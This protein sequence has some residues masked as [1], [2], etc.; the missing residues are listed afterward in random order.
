MTF[1]L[2][3]LDELVSQGRGN[4]TQAA[5]D[6]LMA[7]AGEER[8]LRRNA[9]AYD[10][11][12]L[13]PRFL[14]GNSPPDT[15]ADVM[16]CRVSLPVLTAP[17]GADGTLHPD[18][19]KAVAQ[20]CQDV[21]TVAVVPASS[22]FAF[23]QVAAAAPQ[24]A[25]VAQVHAAGSVQAFRHLLTRISN[26]GYASVCVT[27]DTPTRGWRDRVRNSDVVRDPQLRNANYSDESGGFLGELH[28]QTVPTW[29]WEQLH[30]VCSTSSL[31]FSV[32]GLLS[33][34]DALLAADAGAFAVVV[35]NHGGRQLDGTPTVA[36]VL[37]D[38]VRV[39]GDRVEIV[40]DSGIRRA[41]DIAKAMCLGAS[42]VLV[43]KLA[44]A[45]LAAAGRDGVAQMLQLLQ[46][47]LAN[48]MSQLGCARTTCFDRALLRRRDCLC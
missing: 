22:P 38:F 36:D 8:T 3:N 16:G 9:R 33:P 34:A 14:T 29:R 35:S 10:H 5:W 23:E 17:F 43:G 44:G 4:V 31:P 48:V 15:S 6:Y 40:V 20:A 37:P 32:K 1:E 30:D 46:E 28:K 7:G 41:T 21:G 2:F 11:W 12:D 42:G 45:A 24:A 25:K 13:V 26:A 47:E 19:Q 18:G 27:V 39:A